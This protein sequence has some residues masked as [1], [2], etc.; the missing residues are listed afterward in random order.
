MEIIQQCPNCRKV[1]VVRSITLHFAR[2]GISGYGLLF[3]CP[4]C[5]RVVMR[6]A[7][8]DEAAYIARV[9]AV[10]INRDSDVA[11]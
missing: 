7:E 3:R 8:K 9:G 6:E 5:A 1:M 4:V 10:H 11:K 2:G